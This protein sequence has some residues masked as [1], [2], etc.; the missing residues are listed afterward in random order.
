MMTRQLK[1]RWRFGTIRAELR[2]AILP[3]KVCP[4][5]LSHPR[6]ITFAR[7]STVAADDLW[8]GR[9]ATHRG[10]P[11]G[12]PFWATWP[13]AILTRTQIHPGQLNPFE[14]CFSIVQRRYSR[15]MTFPIWP[16]SN[17]GSCHSS[18]GI[19][20]PPRLQGRRPRYN[21]DYRQT[22]NAPGRLTEKCLRQSERDF[23]A[24]VI[25]RLKRD[26]FRRYPSLAPDQYAPENCATRHQADC[27]WLRSGRW[28]IRNRQRIRQ[29]QHR[30]W[31][32]RFFGQVHQTKLRDRLVNRRRR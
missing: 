25:E 23:W 16:T 28:W 7:S 9:C 29:H 4:T 11:N 5:T 10:R 1:R 15:P 31:R 14:S 20:G 3:L 6:S 19:G 32:V 30:P 22:P 27:C 26:G 24:K 13:N 18:V 17:N 21:P 12:S 8:L 2:S